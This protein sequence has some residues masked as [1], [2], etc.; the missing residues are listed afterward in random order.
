MH[1]QFT[2]QTINNNMFS[3]KNGNVGMGHTGYIL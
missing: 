2:E 1:I 3:I